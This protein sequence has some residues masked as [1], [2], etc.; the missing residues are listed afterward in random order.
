MLANYI[1]KRS[2]Q[3]ALREQLIL[4]NDSSLPVLVHDRTPEQEVLDILEEEGNMKIGVAI[5]G[6]AKDLTYA[7]RRIN[8]GICL[9]T[10][11]RGISQENSTFEETIK[12]ISLTYLLTETDSDNPERVVV[13]VKKIAELKNL[14]M[15]EVGKNLESYLT[16]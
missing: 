13:V 16:V 6:F 2:Q 10:E 5:Y 12:Q 11:L 1:D 15:H 14:S 7:K 9:S 8:N 4:A 3:A